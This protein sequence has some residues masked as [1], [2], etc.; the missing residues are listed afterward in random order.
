MSRHFATMSCMVERASGHLGDTHMVSMSSW[1]T[2]RPLFCMRAKSS[3]TSWSFISGAMVET[4]ICRSAMFWMVRMLR[5]H[6]RHSLPVRRGAEFL[7]HGLQLG[8]I[9]SNDVA[10]RHPLRSAVH[11]GRPEAEVAGEDVDVEPQRWRGSVGQDGGR[12]GVFH[13][14]VDAE[15]ALLAVH[16]EFVD[17]ALGRGL[18][19]EGEEP[20]GASLEQ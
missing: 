12:Q 15:Q 7:L 14:G 11:H 17:L 10:D 13:G 8:G 20:D 3:I 5:T 2:L 6:C 19:P 16:D 4:M 9:V 18:L 1:V